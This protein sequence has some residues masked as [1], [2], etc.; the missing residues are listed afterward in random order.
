MASAGYEEAFF[1][2]K[3]EY[4]E[5]L[6]SK[7]SQH[8][9]LQSSPEA[10]RLV[11]LGGGTGNFT[12][13]LVDFNCLKQRPLCVDPFQEM[14]DRAVGH[15]SVDTCCRGAVEFS[16]EADRRYDRVL[17][18]EMVHH[19][20]EEQLS[21]LYAGLARQLTPGGV[22]LT[23]TRPQEVDYPLF[24]AARQVRLTYGCPLL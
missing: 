23:C 8:L 24:A 4:Q 16:Q 5:H 21:V 6:V 19:V 14:L 13:A 3:G 7:V 22:V 2:A 10:V 20:P 17:L 18:K 12:Q 1:Y 11:D 9:D 15:P